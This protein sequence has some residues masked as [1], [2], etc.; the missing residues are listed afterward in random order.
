MSRRSGGSG[1]LLGLSVLR[2]PMEPEQRAFSARPDYSPVRLSTGA[3]RPQV[4]YFLGFA[5]HHHGVRADQ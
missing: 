1:L 3:F 4:Q 5:G 2:G